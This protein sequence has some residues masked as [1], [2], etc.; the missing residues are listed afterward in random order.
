MK[1]TLVYLI[2]AILSTVGCVEEDEGGGPDG[3][4]AADTPRTAVPAELVGAWEHG[5]IDFELWE[6][7]PEGTYAGRHATPSREAMV[8]GEDGDAKFYR[9]EFARNLYEE[10]I[11]CEGTVTFHS[12]GTFTFYPVR[13]RKRFNDFSNPHRT[14]D[15]A[16][17]ADEL[18][19]P[20]L[21][22]TRAYE[23]LGASDPPAVRITVPSSAPYNWYKKSEG[24]GDTGGL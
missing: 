20:K 24:L 9:Y 12:D 8:F 2:A 15:R 7:Y 4:P 18:L 10:L 6:D 16:L 19:D 3:V 21:A 1:T 23:Y 5:W 13:G 17:R 22:G 11:D 14:V